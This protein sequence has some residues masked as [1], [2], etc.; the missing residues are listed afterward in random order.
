MFGKIDRL[1]HNV[2]ICEN[3]ATTTNDTDFYL[4]ITSEKRQQHLL[5]H[6]PYSVSSSR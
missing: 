2:S 5:Q 4:V 1:S 3:V 6:P